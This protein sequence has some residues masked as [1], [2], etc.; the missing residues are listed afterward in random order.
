MYQAIDN[1]DKVFVIAQQATKYIE[2]GLISINTVFSNAVAVIASNDFGL[3]GLLTCSFHKTWARYFGSY[4]LELIRY[5]P[6]DLLETFPF[7]KDLGV[8]H[9]I[10]KRY[11]LYR[12]EIML[13]HKEGLTVIYNR[14]HDPQEKGGDIIRL[15]EL[16]LD[17]DNAVAA[18]Y[19]WGDLE[20]GHGFHETAQGVRY[21]ISEAARRE[22]LVRLLKL[23]HERYEE[24][25][26]AGLHEKKKGGKGNKGTKRKARTVKENKGQYGLF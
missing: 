22:V 17:M 14:F 15:R 6:S 5:A 25:V 23:N 13:A 7:P 21:T 24:E 2:F 10:G 18:A 1:F 8:L 12:Q 16:H 11:F 9:I 3:F 19:G 20:L 4:N 26:K